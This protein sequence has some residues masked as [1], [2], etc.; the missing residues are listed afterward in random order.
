MDVTQPV[1]SADAVEFDPFSDDFFNA[2]F[3]RTAVFATKHRSTTTRSTAFGR[4]RA[5]RTSSPR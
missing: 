1:I 3:E 2:P 5:T 4:C